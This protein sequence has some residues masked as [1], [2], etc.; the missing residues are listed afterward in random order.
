MR[1]LN[2]EH[3]KAET[4]NFELFNNEFRRSSTVP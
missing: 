4:F 2:I 3:T 1:T